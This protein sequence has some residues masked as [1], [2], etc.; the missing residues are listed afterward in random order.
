M[1]HYYVDMD[2]RKTGHHQL[3]RQGCE[4][5]PGAENRYYIGEHDTTASALEEAGIAFSF[6]KRCPWCST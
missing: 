2:A 3:H 1:A 6:V 4:R 5:M